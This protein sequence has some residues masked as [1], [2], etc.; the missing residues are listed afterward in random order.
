[1]PVAD[2]ETDVD[3][4]GT[5]DRDIGDVGILFQLGDDDIGQRA[6]VGSE[7]FCQHHCGIGRDIAM[8]RVTRRLD[9]DAAEIE[10]RSLFPDQFYLFKG[11]FDPG[12]EVGKRFIALFHA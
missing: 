9:G 10:L 4:A 6:R 7:R 11:G 3:E 2:G 1:M 12:F 5:R 8:A